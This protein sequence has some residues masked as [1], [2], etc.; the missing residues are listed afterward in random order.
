MKEE[1]FWWDIHTHKTGQEG[2]FIWNAPDGA[3]ELADPAEGGLLQS[4][5]SATLAL[6]LSD[7]ASL[8]LASV[9]DGVRYSVYVSAGLHPWYLT[10]ENLWQRMRWLRQAVEYP[11]VVA[12]GEAGLD[13]LSTTPF[14]V[15]CEAFVQVLQLADEHRLPLLI[16]AVK[17]SNELICLKNEWKPRNPWI[18]HGF[19]GKSELAQSYLKHGFYL[20]F[21]EKYHPEALRVTPIERLFLETDDS[22]ADIRELYCRAAEIRGVLPEN[23]RKMIEQNVNTLFFRR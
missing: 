1:L 11:Q 12:M 13:K 17:T 20:S 10:T 3:P 23:L 16:H 14:D 8:P 18:I 2:G 19:R 15:Q 9:A 4:D 22:E 6:S 7:T 5:S 21:G